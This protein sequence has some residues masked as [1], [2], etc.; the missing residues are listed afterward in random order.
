MKEYFKKE[1]NDII[2]VDAF[3][4]T[5]RKEKKNKEDYKKDIVLHNI[6]YDDIVAIGAAVYTNINI[7]FIDKTK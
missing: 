5:K 7:K 3:S 6:N 1:I 4:T 2:E